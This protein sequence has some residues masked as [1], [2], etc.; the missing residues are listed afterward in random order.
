MAQPIASPCRNVCRLDA[1]QICVGCGRSIGEIAEWPTAAEPRRR[2]IVLQ[3]ARR[4]QGATM[5]INASARNPRSESHSLDQFAHRL[6]LPVRWG[7]MDAMGHVNNVKFFTFDESVR[8]AYFE[9]LAR[10]D[11]TFMKSHGMILAHIGA[12]FI[13]QLHYPATLQAGLRVAKI[14][15]SSLNTVAAMFSEGKLIAVTKGVLVWFDYANQKTMPI[16][17]HVREMIRKRERIAPD[18]A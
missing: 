7:D 8:I 2:E 16:P 1:G 15:K 12:D 6:E 14:G 5:S 18:E 17:E 9:E 11:A 3:A 4:M 10:A 13:A